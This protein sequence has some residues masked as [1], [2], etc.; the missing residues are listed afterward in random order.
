MP[1]V[2]RTLVLHEPPTPRGALWMMRGINVRKY[3]TKYREKPESAYAF[4]LTMCNYYC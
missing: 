2:D 3:M 1:Q 4:I